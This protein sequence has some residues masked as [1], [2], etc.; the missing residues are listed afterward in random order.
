ALVHANLAEGARLKYPNQ[1][2]S[3]HLQNCEERDDKKRTG[4]VTVA[5]QFLEAAGLCLGQTAQQL[6]DPSL[7]RDLLWRQHHRR[8][9]AGALEDAL[10]RGEQAEEIDL[11]FRLVLVARGVCNARIR[12]HPLRTPPCLALVPQLRSSL[13]LLMLH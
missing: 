8:S 2:Q 4:A 11:Q 13:V 6:L 10:E 7:E 9:P 12:A 3:N 1:L 5:E